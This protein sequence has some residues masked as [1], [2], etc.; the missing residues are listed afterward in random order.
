MRHGLLVSTKHMTGFTH[1]YLLLV[2]DYLQ[3]LSAW[4]DLLV[5]THHLSVIGCITCEY[6]SA[7]QE[8]LASTF[9]SSVIVH[10]QCIPHVAWAQHTSYLQNFL[11][12]EAGYM[13]F[14]NFDVSCTVLNF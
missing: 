10:E 6:K 9:N 14:V 5:G 3:V 12:H 1:E 7:Q 11:R 13:R 2:S 4:Q 8:L